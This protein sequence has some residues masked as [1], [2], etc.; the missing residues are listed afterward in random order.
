MEGGV[1]GVEG[2]MGIRGA[3]IPPLGLEGAPESRAEGGAGILG[4]AEA[5]A[6]LDGAPA[7]LGE[8]IE[9]VDRLRGDRAL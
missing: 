6:G 5:L 8:R 3:R 1:G 2:G 7:V 9:D 4:T